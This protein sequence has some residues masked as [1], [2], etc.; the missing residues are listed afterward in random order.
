MMGGNYKLNYGHISLHRLNAALKR[1]L[2]F[3]SPLTDTMTQC[4]GATALAALQEKVT[5][6]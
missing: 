2:N 4:K 6:T 1:S 3:I 5:A